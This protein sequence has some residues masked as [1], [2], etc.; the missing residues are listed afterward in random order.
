MD[1]AVEGE[2]IERQH[3]ME[4]EQETVDELVVE[5]ALTLA[6]ID[7]ECKTSFVYSSLYRCSINKPIFA[8]NWFW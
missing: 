2:A 7:H 1:N 3:I 6:D 8:L 4:A 5:D